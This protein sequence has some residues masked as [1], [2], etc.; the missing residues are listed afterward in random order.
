[1]H[2]ETGIYQHSI[3]YYYDTVMPTSIKIKKEKEIHV[4][5]IWNW[6]L[7]YSAMDSG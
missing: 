5:G 1:M 6:S 7:R 2:V 3:T 4:P